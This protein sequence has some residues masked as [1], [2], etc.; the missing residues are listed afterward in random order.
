M[1]KLRRL[2]PALVHVILGGYAQSALLALSMSAH[3]VLIFLL[4]GKLV[5]SNGVE[6]KILLAVPN[7]FNCRHDR[8]SSLILIHPALF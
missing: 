5:V 1:A 7:T 6:L 8:S 3:E 4:K 2:E